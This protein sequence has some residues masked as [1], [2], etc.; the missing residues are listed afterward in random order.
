MIYQKVK[1]GF[2]VVS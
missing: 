2:Y 1:N